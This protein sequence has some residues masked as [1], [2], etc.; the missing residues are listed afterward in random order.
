MLRYEGL[1]HAVQCDDYIQTHGRNTGCKLQNL[2]QA[3]YIDFNVCVNGSSEA[4]WLRP[5]YFTFHL[6]NL[7]NNDN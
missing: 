2:R 6:Q 3:E 5:S 4:T 1:D 7:G